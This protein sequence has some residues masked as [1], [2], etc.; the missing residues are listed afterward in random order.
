MRTVRTT[1]LLL[2]VTAA[3]PVHLGADTV[4]AAEAAIAGLCRE[5][6]GEDSQA[7]IALGVLS[8]GED[9]DLT[10]TAAPGS[11]L[12]QPSRFLLWQG[13]R[14][15]GWVAATVSVTAPRVV[16]ARAIGRDEVLD[17]A[18]LRT[19]AGPLPG[20]AIT[21]LPGLADVVGAS[22]RRP[23]LEGEVIVS[24]AVRETF[25]VRTGDTVQARIRRGRLEIVARV[26]ASGTG[27]V[28]DVIR[29]KHAGAGRAV[30]ARITGPG[31][32]E[33]LP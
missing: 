17:G 27:R 25:A 26:M 7:A 30:A 5:V 22:A 32:V 2:A 28:G 8:L 11:R 10:A 16:A 13:R 31:A 18:A 4:R 24:A 21:R 6:F 23:I 15:V 20:V 9:G 14:Q 12:G 1:V 33:V 3:Q 19:G 29:V